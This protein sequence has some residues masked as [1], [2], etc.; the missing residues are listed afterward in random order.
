MK[1]DFLKMELCGIDL[2][3]VFAQYNLLEAAVHEVAHGA[4]LGWMRLGTNVTKRV[5]AK[6]TGME[7]G[8][9]M[10]DWNEVRTIAVTHQVGLLLGDVFEHIAFNDLLAKA[11][12][13]GNK[14]IDYFDAFARVKDS[15][16]T[17][18]LAKRVVSWL[19]E[20]EID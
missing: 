14:T 1:F 17:K 19:K 8:G 12:S 11:Y 10:D 18:R 20:F 2:S 9:K 4:V 3:S 5:N 7:E 16:S 6:L 15:R 13:D